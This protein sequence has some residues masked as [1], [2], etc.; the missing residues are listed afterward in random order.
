MKLFDG[1][2]DLAMNAIENE[3]DQTLSVADIRARE[4]PPPPGGRGTCMVSLPELRAGGTAV[5]V[6]TVIARSKPWIDPRRALARED[7]DWPSPDMA[8]AVAS[9][10]LAYYERLQRRGELSIL[11]T[12][13]DLESHWRKATRE[14]SG[15]S[16][17]GGEGPGV[18]VMMEGADPVAEPEEVRLWHE[19]G[20]R[21][22]SLAHFGHSHYACGTP[23]SD[24][25]SPERDGPLKPAA[26]EL[27]RHM[28]QL[29]MVLDL[30]HLSDRSF[31]E[32]VDAFGGRICATHSNSRT[33]SDSPRQIT[34]EQ[35]R[36]VFERDGVVGLAI[37]NAML[38]WTGSWE[39]VPP[40]EQVPLR[41]VVDHIRHFCDLAGDT[42]HVGIGSD[43]DGGYG[44][45][46]TPLELDTHRDLRKLAPL[47]IDAGFTDED[48]ANILGENW[49]R[50]WAASLP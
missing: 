45:E 20:L 10:Q 17:G 33:L 41:V 31:A 24:P 42:R 29:G 48:V 26:S 22:L 39:T 49:A 3:R 32:A 11:R 40:R 15:V 28:Q 25:T 21:C 30:T 35:V 37:H 27:L 50:F 8:H 34:D 43:L 36:R 18:I 7:N 1:H 4:T 47:L 16:G 44:R 46:R 13:A 14:P 6:A 19:R 5:V 38:Q 9:G 23:P 12:A 2:L